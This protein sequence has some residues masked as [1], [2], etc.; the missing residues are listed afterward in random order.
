M[1]ERIYFTVDVSGTS[2]LLSRFV[3]LRLACL[4]FVFLLFS[5]YD[6]RL[7]VISTVSYPRF[8]QEW[9]HGHHDCHQHCCLDGAELKLLAAASSC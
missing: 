5:G 1:C 7:C 3:P 9:L 6:T 2:N 8:C 4:R